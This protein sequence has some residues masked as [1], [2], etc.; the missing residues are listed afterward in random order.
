MLKP[1]G[2]QAYFSLTE[3]KYVERD[4]ATFANLI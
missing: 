2:D 1:H 3:H 4:F